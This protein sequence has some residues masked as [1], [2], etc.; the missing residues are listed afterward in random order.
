LIDGELPELKHVVGSNFTDI[1]VIQKGTSAVIGV[2][3][4]NLTKGA[5]GQAIQN[6]N[7]ALGLDETSGLLF[8]GYIL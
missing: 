6:M 5:S 8:P 4:D 7:L 2:A 3:L 1:G